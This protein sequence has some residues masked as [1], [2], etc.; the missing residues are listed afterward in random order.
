MVVWFSSDFVTLE[1]NLSV[2]I[3]LFV[4]LESLSCCK[5]EHAFSL[6]FA[7]NNWAGIEVS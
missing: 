7:K 6:L 1:D 5:F 3:V 4:F 2:Y